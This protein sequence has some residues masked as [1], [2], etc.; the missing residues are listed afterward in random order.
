MNTS[1]TEGNA[2]ITRQIT[3]LRV[4]LPRQ[5]VFELKCSA[6]FRPEAMEP[7][8]TAVRIWKFRKREWKMQAQQSSIVLFWLIVCQE[9]AITGWSKSACTPWQSSSQIQVAASQHR[10]VS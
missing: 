2:L 3:I 6:G 9:P 4:T 8:P 7:D 10:L 5:S 1:E